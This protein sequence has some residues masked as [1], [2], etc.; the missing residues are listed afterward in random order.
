MTGRRAPQQLRRGG[1]KCRAPLL[2]DPRRRHRMRRRAVGDARHR[3]TAARRSS[4]AGRSTIRSAALTVTETTSRLRNTHSRGAADEPDEQRR[5]RPAAAAEM[6]VDDRRVIV[7]H[8]EPGHQARRD[9]RRHGQHRRCRPRRARPRPSRNRARRRGPAKPMPAARAPKRISAPHV[10]QQRERRIDKA[11]RQTR[12]AAPAAGRPPPP[13]P[14][15]SAQDLPE[16]PGR[17]PPRRRCSARRPRAAATA[18]ETALCRGRAPRRPSPPHAAR[19]RRSAAEIVARAGAR[20]APR[21]T[22]ASTTATPRD[23][24]AQLQRSPVARSTN[25][26]AASAGPSNVSSAPICPR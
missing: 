3:A 1:A 2:D 13:R 25:G 16:Q 8:D 15:V 14:S 11:L 19:R 21:R 20:H 9:R 18:G 10:R 17:A 7:G 26:K 12:R 24:A 6:R 23:W 4:S 5:D 22:T